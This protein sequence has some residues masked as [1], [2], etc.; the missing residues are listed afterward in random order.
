M[1]RCVSIPVLVLAMVLFV[2]FGSISGTYAQ[3]KK[4]DAKASQTNTDILAKIGS[5]KITK[6]EFEARIASLPPQYQANMQD[7]KARRNF[8]EIFIQAQLFAYAAR[9]EKIDKKA[10]VA[11]Q[12]EDATNGILAQEFVRMKLSDIKKATD[13]EIKKYYD[14][15]KAKLVKPTTVSA[16]HIL[17][18]LENGAKPEEEKVALEKAEKLKKDLDAG[19]DFAKLAKEHSDDP[20]SKDNGGELGY[21][22]E[23]QMVPEFSGPVFKMKVGEISQPIKSPFGYHIVKLND[24]KE[25]STMD[26]KEASPMIESTLMQEKQQETLE[27]E[28]ERLKKK[29]KVVITGEGN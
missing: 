6:K 17:I 4:N 3:S 29:Y 26:L 9:D 15:N 14:E 1:K 22:S 21:F 24:R 10:L 5:K 28:L 8:L 12:I 23:Q 18:K 16:Q 2:C 19:T 25:G 20:G 13:T 11:L 7:E 27:K